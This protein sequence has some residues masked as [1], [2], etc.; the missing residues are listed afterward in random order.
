MGGARVEEAGAL[1]AVGLDGHKEGSTEEEGVA[2]RR[3]VEE[4][5]FAL[6]ALAQVLR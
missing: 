5:D 2:F 1:E 3:E 6:S 4:S